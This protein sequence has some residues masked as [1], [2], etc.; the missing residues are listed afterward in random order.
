MQMLRSQSPAEQHEIDAN[1]VTVMLNTAAVQMELG[2]Y[3]QAAATCSDAL[4][5][6]PGNAKGLL[7]RAKALSHMHDTQAEFIL[8]HCFYMRA[9]SWYLA[10]TG[11]PG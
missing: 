8:V 6:E 2:E 5:L 1:L 7:R 11:G 10:K 3:R 9:S 4:R